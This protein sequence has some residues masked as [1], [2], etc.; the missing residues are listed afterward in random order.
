MNT[1][2]PTFKQSINSLLSYL[3]VVKVVGLIF[4]KETNTFLYKNRIYTPYDICIY[5]LENTDKIEVLEKDYTNNKIYKRT[6]D[7]Y[8]IE[9]FNYYK[10]LLVK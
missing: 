7:D 4:N 1:T 5:I 2:R 6:I 10:S 3:K 9:P 8:D